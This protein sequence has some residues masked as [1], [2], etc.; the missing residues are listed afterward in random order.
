MWDLSSLTRDRICVPHITRQI[1]NHWITRGV[2]QLVFNLSP[3]A[4]GQQCQV[5][6]P[7]VPAEDGRATLE[8]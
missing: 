7:K 3:A 4:E 1:L 6:F 5:R 8:P 2:S